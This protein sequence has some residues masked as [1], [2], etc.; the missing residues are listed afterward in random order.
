MAVI[1]YRLVKGTDLTAAEHDGTLH[2]LDD[3]LI[4]VEGVISDGVSEIE[5]ISQEAGSDQFYFNMSDDRILGPIVL[6]HMQWN[7]REELY[8]L[9]ETVYLEF[10]VFSAIGKL[11]QVVFPHTSS[12]SFDPGANDGIGHDY[13]KLLLDSFGRPRT[14]DN[15]TTEL[16][17]GVNHINAFIRFKNVAGCIIVFPD[18]ATIDL[19]IDTEVQGW[20]DSDGSLSFEGETIDVVINVKTGRGLGTDVN[21]AMWMAKKVAVNEWKL[22]GDLAFTVSS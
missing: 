14:Q 9:P 21:G 2:N 8:W 6:P 3:R 16:F 7:F 5:S 18:D 1:T 20:Q 13:Y 22:L 19:P 15:E 17:L 12:T 11:Y 10:D 4:V